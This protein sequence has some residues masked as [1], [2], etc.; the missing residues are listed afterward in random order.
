MTLD[1]PLFADGAA[2]PAMIATLPLAEGYTTMLRGLN[3]QTMQPEHKRLTVAGTE[4]I[5][6]G[7]QQIPTYRTEVK[8]ADGS[9]GET[10]YF[11]EKDGQHRLL[12]SRALVPALGGAVMEMTLVEEKQ[13][14]HDNT[15]CVN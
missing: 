3:G 13:T 15:N 5:E 6:F 14:G 11:V 2:E 1:G 4:D 10:V 9:A 8:P 12:K 7:G